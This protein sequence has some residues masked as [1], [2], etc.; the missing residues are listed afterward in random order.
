[1]TDQVAAKEHKLDAGLDTEGVLDEDTLLKV[2]NLHTYLATEAGLVK[3]V[4]GVDIT[5]KKEEVLGVVGESGCGKS[6]TALSIMQLLPQPH[7]KIHQGKILFRTRQGRVIDLAG[8]DPTGQVMRRIRGNEIAVIFQEPMTS[9]N[10]VYTVGYQ[11]VEAIM[12]HRQVTRKQAWRM[13][14]EMLAKVGI[15]SPK[16]RVGEYPYQMSGGMRQRVM[17]AMALCCSP[18]LLIADEPTTALDV[19]IQAQILD[20]MMSLQEEFRMSIMMITHNLGVVGRICDN[21]AVMYMGKIIEYTDVRT[22]Y[23]NPAHPYTIGLFNSIPKLGENKQRLVPI[24]G[25]VP[26]PVHLPEGCSFKDRCP[27]ATEKCSEEPP[28]VSVG[29][30]HFARC[31]HPRA[32]AV[33]HLESPEALDGRKEQDHGKT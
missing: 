1:M 20:L 12:L 13:A 26:D 22:L 29:R 21:V 27:A 14:E 17:I 23:H 3:A 8:Q 32:K 2:E 24:K 5:V 4:N 25:V 11:I 31:W 9:L 15:P 19:T 16:Q 30:D 18:S 7:G 10:P 6:I 33:D 28:F